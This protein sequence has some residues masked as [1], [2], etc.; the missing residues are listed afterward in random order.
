MKLCYLKATLVHATFVLFTP[1]LLMCCTVEASVEIDVKCT[2]YSQ[3]EN[4]EGNDVDVRTFV[5]GL[6]ANTEYISQVI[7]DH[8]PPTNVTTKT[9]PEGIFWS[10]AKIPNG[11]KST[12]FKVKV[13][14]VGDLDERLIASGDDDEPCHDIVF[15][16]QVLK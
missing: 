2:I 15:Q 8:N 3:I 1:F 6:K 12:L 16:S 11:E 13:F 5:L 14:E 4:P 7:P 9:D 10:V